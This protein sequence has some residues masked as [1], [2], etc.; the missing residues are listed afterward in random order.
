MEDA[1][2]YSS[3]ADILA[4]KFTVVS[5]NRRCNSRNSGD[6]SADM[7]VAQQARDAASIIMNGS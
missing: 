3:T 2:F 1:G 4:E 7:T 5:Y 6:R